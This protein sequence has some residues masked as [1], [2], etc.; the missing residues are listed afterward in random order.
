MKTRHHVYLLP[1]MALLALAACDDDGTMPLTEEPGLALEDQV[2][3]EVLGDDQAIEAALAL[4]EVSATAGARHG[5]AH[6]GSHAAT[7]LSAE[8]RIRFRAAQDALAR[9]DRVRAANESRE[10]RR[11]VAEAMTAM[12]GPRAAWSQ[13]ERMEY[14]MASV[15]EDPTAYSDAATLLGELGAFA[16][17]ARARLHDGNGLGAG[18]LGVL[19]QQRHHQQRR[20]HDPAARRDRADLAVSLA[21]SAVSLAT[22]ILDGQDPDDEQ[23]RYL[24]AAREYLDKAEAALEAGNDSRAIYL[25]EHAHWASLKALVLPGGVT[26]EETRGMADLAE[27]RYRA[28]LEA[29]GD[30]PTELQS[31]LL[32]RARRLV[33]AGMAK[34]EEGQHRGVGALWRAAVICTWLIA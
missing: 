4:A 31:A 11:L 33:D 1:L 25:A 21:G 30:D 3:L 24:G 27:E 15:S 26:V 20:E 19:A 6:A 16:N 9:G 10:A 12:G 8:A 7:Q 22:R 32:R 14:L 23:L 17:R 28:A 34:L 29:V 2:A 18:A 5:F 13:V